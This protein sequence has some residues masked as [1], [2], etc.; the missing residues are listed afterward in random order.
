MEVVSA[1]L[2]SLPQ[3]IACS[4]FNPHQIGQNGLQD[5][6]LNSTLIIVQ[7]KEKEASDDETCK[8]ADSL[9]ALGS[10]TLQN[11]FV[12]KTFRNISENELSHQIAN[13]H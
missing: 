9:V 13:L 5:G 8:I 10:D 2:D 3:N 6:T 4:V 1:V 12:L 11:N 7:S